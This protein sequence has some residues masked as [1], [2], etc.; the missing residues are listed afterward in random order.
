M[1]MSW[2]HKHQDEFSVE[3]VNAKNV[4]DH[5]FILVFQDMFLVNF[6]TFYFLCPVT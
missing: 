5:N 1:V 3:N 2:W 4:T 6:A